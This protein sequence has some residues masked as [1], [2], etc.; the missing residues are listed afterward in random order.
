MM[1]Q[2][3]KKHEWSKKS[4]K[5]IELSKKRGYFLGGEYFF[6]DEENFDDSDS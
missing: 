3:K 1:F 4:T 2:I 6:L 5:V